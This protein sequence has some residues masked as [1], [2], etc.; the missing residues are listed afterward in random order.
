[1]QL[2]ISKF[3][4]LEFWLLLSR[5]PPLQFVTT[6]CLIPNVK[7]IKIMLIISMY[8]KSCRIKSLKLEIC[9][10]DDSENSNSQLL[11]MIRL[12]WSHKT[13]NQK[14]RIQWAMFKNCLP[15]SKFLKLPAYVDNFIF[16]LY[17]L[18]YQISLDAIF[19]RIS[20]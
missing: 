16:L 8:R 1:M 14:H 11:K 2:L 6:N 4:S 7:L 5:V 18:L 9:Q 10:E 3:N 12:L 19:I 20:K 15:V 13:N 17:D